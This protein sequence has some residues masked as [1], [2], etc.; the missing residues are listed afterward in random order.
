[1]TEMFS[2][3]DK[4]QSR[5]ERKKLLILWFTALAVYLVAVGVM[6]G[7][8]LYQVE[9]T[10]SRAL[11]VPFTVLAVALSVLFGC[12]TLFFFSIKYRL[13]AKYCRMLKDID[14]GL[15]DTTEGTFL[16]YDD[17]ITMKDG[18]YFYAMELDCKPL[19]R[20]DITLRKVLIEQTIPHP[21]VAEGEK[22]RFTTHAN[23]LISY[24]SLG[25][26]PAAAEPPTTSAADKGQNTESNGQGDQ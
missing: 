10:A 9:T 15:K 1:M 17:T 21:D 26:P 20:D 8:N 12:F 22:I 25:R 24:E 6:I 13:T 19:R 14:R 2:Q 5:A 11:Q 7:V 3:A 4:T 16:R 18:V 23:I